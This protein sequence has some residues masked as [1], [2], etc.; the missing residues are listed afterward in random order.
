MY[1]SY[2]DRGINIPDVRELYL[3]YK[4]HHAA[5]LMKTEDGRRVLM[6]DLTLNYTKFAKFHRLN[7]QID[8]ACQH[9]NIEWNDWEVFK[10]GEIDPKNE[11]LE[12]DK[13]N[14][15]KINFIYKNTNKAI[16]GTL[17]KFNTILT[18][19][20]KS[21]LAALMYKM[22]S[23]KNLY[24]IR[25][26]DSTCSNSYFNNC[27]GIIGDGLTRFIIKSRCG[28]IW[29]AQK[30]LRLLNKG[31]GLCSCGKPG[32]FNHLM[33]N[34][35]HQATR[36][37]RRHNDIVNIIVQ[38]AKMHKFKEIQ[39]GGDNYAIEED[40]AIKLPHNIRDTTE[41]TPEENV[42]RE[43]CCQSRPDVWF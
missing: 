25:K 30:K 27:K 41:W 43:E 42:Y 24:L 32:Y 11:N 18:N 4:L 37:T 40:M 35:L 19:R 26:G 20:E 1:L 29:D 33:N 16:T 14:K 9:S 21:A 13:Y 36:M 23:T 5:H 28:L 7:I 34:C 12:R 6:G 8:E 31:D 2:K 38:A 17:K 39:D 10:S 22:Y 3:T 15:L